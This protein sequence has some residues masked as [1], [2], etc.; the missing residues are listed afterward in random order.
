MEMEEDGI[1]VDFTRKYKKQG[2]NPLMTNILKGRSL[3]R[4]T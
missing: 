3:K 2:T 1:L 4:E